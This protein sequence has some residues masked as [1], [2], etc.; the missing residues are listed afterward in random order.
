GHNAAL[1]G[2]LRR[3]VTIHLIDIQVTRFFLNQLIQD[4]QQHL[5]RRAPLGSKLNKS[6]SILF[7]RALK[8]GCI[9]L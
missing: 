3:F 9:Y 4:G 5:A 2:K 1:S 7:N 8:A 6:D